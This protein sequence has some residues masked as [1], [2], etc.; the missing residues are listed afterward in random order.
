M[1]GEGVGWSEV[2]WGLRVVGRG[3][4]MG[5]EVD[6]DGGRAIS[7]ELI[8]NSRVPHRRFINFLIRGRI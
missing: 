5:V 1:D 3:Q 4:G 2:R 6:G 8:T 7:F